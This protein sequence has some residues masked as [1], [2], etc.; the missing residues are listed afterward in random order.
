MLY[1]IYLRNVVEEEV[2]VEL[3]FTLFYLIIS[4]TCGKKLSRRNTSEMGEWDG[5]MK[6]LV[7]IAQKDFVSWL[8]EGAH[9]EGELSANF[10]TRDRDGDN[11]W[12]LRVEEEPSL[13]HLEFQLKPDENM[14]RRMWE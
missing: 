14:D 1:L 9:F 10:A 2:G 5:Q 7:G 12:Q 3:V 6:H 11:L 8:V 13:L 4:V